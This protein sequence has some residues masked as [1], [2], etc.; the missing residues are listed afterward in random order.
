[1]KCLSLKSLFEL[2]QS[3]KIFNLS[4]SLIFC[5]AYCGDQ[6]SCMK[7]YMKREARGLHTLGSRHKE[8][9]MLK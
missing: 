7:L 9:L 5:K 3:F 1:M 2:K 6:I 8:S 4:V